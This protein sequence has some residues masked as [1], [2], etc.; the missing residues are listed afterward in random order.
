MSN[1]PITTPPATENISTMTFSGCDISFDALAGHASLQ[2]Q[3]EA[4]VTSRASSVPV[5]LVWRNLVF[6]VPLSKK[7]SHQS[8]PEPV[9]S[10][11]TRT[12]LKPGMKRILHH[13]SGQVRCGQV[14]AI[15]GASG[16]G[17]TTMLNMLS[18]RL[19]SSN[20]CTTAG[21]VYVNGQSRNFDT[22]RHIAKFVEQ[23]DTSMFAELTVREQILYAARLALSG[24]VTEAQKI[25]RVDRIIQELG[26]SKAAN[27]YIGSEIVRGVSGGERRRAAIGVELVTDPSL[28]F[29]DEPTTGLDSFNALNVMTS[30]RHLAKNDRTIITTIHQPRSSIFHM[31]DL[32]CLIAEGHIV[33]FGPASEAAAHFANLG[34]RSPPHFNVADFVIDVLS[35]DHRS[36]EKE[37]STTARI[38]FI[39]EYYRERIEPSFLADADAYEAVHKVQP[40]GNQMQYSN[41]LLQEFSI[42]TKR[43]VVLMARE[44]QINIM[45]LGQNLFFAIVLGVLWLDSGRSDGRE[46]R[47]AIAGVLF[48]LL[49]NQYVLNETCHPKGLTF[50]TN[51][52]A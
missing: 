34:F 23:D 31:F 14:L 37:V 5:D 49:V 44:R 26:L 50:C 21:K 41:N 51:Y 39:A 7:D 35:I 33:Y 27:T 22:F 4:T 30:L 17:K 52:R 12:P 28:I 20:K 8:V 42:L 18:G 9:S 2:R 32:L 36:E 19:K 47:R 40:Q 1:P 45:R 25:A 38:Q 46:D 13:V 16:S 48:F 10:N 29:L 15:M 3:L 6:D 43:T 11:Q 24:E